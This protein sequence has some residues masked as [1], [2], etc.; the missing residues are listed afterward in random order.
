VLC[1]AVM[2]SIAGTIPV[3]AKYLLKCHALTIKWRTTY[4]LYCSPPGHR[5]DLSSPITG[6]C[7]LHVSRQRLATTQDMR[8][9]S[10]LQSELPAAVTASTS[11]SSPDEVS[12]SK[13]GCPGMATVQLCH[14]C[15]A[16]V[17]A[18]SFIL[19][20]SGGIASVTFFPAPCIDMA[21]TEKKSKSGTT[22][23]PRG[24]SASAPPKGRKESV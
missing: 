1:T 9:V 3:R 10:S 2:R 11:C 16:R 13:Q 15:S 5:A 18:G 8:S 20:R 7:P 21:C 6:T 4:N 12:S 19:C 17:C 22:P 23:Y 14:N 24:A